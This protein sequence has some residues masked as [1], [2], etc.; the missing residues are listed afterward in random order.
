MRGTGYWYIYNPQHPNYLPDPPAEEEAPQPHEEFV[1]GGLH[2]I[3]TLEGPQAQLSPTHLVLEHI[4]QAAIQGETI[5]VDIQPIASTSQVVINPAPQP[6]TIVQQPQAPAMAQPAQIT[7]QL[8]QPAQQQAPVQAQQQA[9]QPAQQ[10]AQAAAA[11]VGNGA[12]KGSA[13]PIFKGERSEST[14][15]LMAFR[16]F[17]V[18]NRTNETLVNPVTRIATALTYMDGPLINPWK[19][20][21]MGK[22]ED[23]LAAGVPDI[24]KDHWT[25]FLTDFEAAFGNTNERQDS[26]SKL[27]KLEQGDDL[28]LYI[29]TFRHL[30]GKARA[31]LDDLGTTEIFKYGLKPGLARKIMEMPTFDPHTPWT[32]QQWETAAKDSHMKWLNQKEFS[33]QSN[34]VRQ[35]LHRALNIQGQNNRNHNNQRGRRTTSQGGDAMDI[36]TLRGPDLSPEEKDKLMKANAC[37]YCTKPGH[38]ARE[39]RKKARD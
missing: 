29:T 16:I 24:S 23:R 8:A 38:R 33:D 37:F 6:T 30:A 13:P 22:L 19:E 31:N 32:F 28:D 34:K 3:A 21:Q 39:C 35:G 17:C 18:A 27:T 15:F 14:K 11:H 4:E 36:D 10:Q 1:A 12:F 2:H 20:D 5:P 26:W 25:A 9:Q 7:M